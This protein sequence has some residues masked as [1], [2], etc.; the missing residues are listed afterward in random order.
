M[1]TQP[2]IQ[3]SVAVFACAAAG[4]ILQRGRTPLHLAATKGHVGVSEQ[5]LAAQADPNVRDKVG[6]RRGLVD[7][8]GGPGHLCQGRWGVYG[9]CY[10]WHRG[11]AYGAAAGGV[12]GCTGW[13]Q[14][15]C[16]PALMTP[17]PPAHQRITQRN[18]V[19]V[20][21]CV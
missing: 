21:M 14:G 10:V 17:G 12:R 3:C 7:D 16:V 5:L 19:Y 6:G 4:P 15:R 20:Y 9:G 1:T 11:T 2:L 13:C 18:V 8:R